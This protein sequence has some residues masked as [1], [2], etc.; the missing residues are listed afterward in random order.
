MARTRERDVEKL[1][2]LG[3]RALGG[4]AFKF[5]SPGRRG[6][7]D[8][9]VVLPANPQ[10]RI[11]WVEL[12]TDGGTVSPWQNREIEWLSRM[13]QRVLVLYGARDVKDWLATLEQPE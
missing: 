10:P 5:V 8:R 7:P 6:V 1:L 12:K 4:R 9:V 13:G 3:V 2:R 11:Y